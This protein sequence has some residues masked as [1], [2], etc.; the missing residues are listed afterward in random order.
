V[1]IGELA[2]RLQIR[3]HSAV[4]LVDRMVIL[5]LVERELSTDDRRQV[6]VVLTK[7]GRTLLNQ[8]VVAHLEELQRIK[9]YL[10]QL[11]QT[12]GSELT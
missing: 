8:L 12:F 2:E 1:T 6:Y 3:H 7:D 5:G 11:L 4:G 10:S 9:P